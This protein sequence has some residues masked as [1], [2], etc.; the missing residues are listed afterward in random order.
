MLLISDLCPPATER[1]I[2]SATD[3]PPQEGL[4]SLTDSNLDLS[5]MGPVVNEFLMKLA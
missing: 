5:R 3:W 2:A 1:L 4:P